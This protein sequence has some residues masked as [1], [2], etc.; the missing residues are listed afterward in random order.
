MPAGAG[1]LVL[2]FFLLGIPGYYDEEVICIRE[3]LHF[4]GTRLTED[5]CVDVL[6]THP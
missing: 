2:S 6:K 5:G 4:A 3:G 1:C